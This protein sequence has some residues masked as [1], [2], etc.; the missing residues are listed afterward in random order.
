MHGRLAVFVG[1]VPACG[2]GTV[3]LAV[4]RRHATA[5]TA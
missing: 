3:W 2:G 1:I 5:S 4:T